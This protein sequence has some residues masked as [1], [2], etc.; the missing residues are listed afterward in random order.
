VPLSVGFRFSGVNKGN[1]D[2][3]ETEFGALNIA[4]ILATK[5]ATPEHRLIGGMIF[6][7]CPK[8]KA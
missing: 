7:F 1:R 8:T 3:P 5:E 2:D 4:I 6:H